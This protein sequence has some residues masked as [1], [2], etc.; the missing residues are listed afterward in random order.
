MVLTTE[1]TMKK[2]ILSSV[3][4]GLVLASGVEASTAAAPQKAP[5]GAFVINADFAAGY[6]ANLFHKTPDGLKG[7]SI[8][9]DDWMKRGLVA[10]SDSKMTFK[11]EGGCSAVAFGAV[12]KLNVNAA[13]KDFTGLLRDTYVFGRF[14]NMV[15]VRVG[16][17]RDAMCSMVDADSLMGGTYGYNGYYGNLL[18][19]T[20]SA[21][22]TR[23]DRFILDLGHKND[24]WYTNAIEVRTVRMA[25]VQAILNWKPSA[26]YNGRLGTYGDGTRIAGVANNI[27]SASVNYDNT[28]G[29]FRVRLSAG[30]VYELSDRTDDAGVKIVEQNANVTYRIGSAFS[31]K[32]FDFGL[33]WADDCSTGFGAGNNKDGNAGKKVHGVVGYQFDTMW[34]PRISVGALYGWKNGAKDAAI[35]DNDVTLAVSGAV[36]FNIRNG[37]RWFVEGTWAA[38]DY[39]NKTEA[40]DKGLSEPNLILGTGLAVSQ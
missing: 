8:D 37:L 26:A 1:K 30:S 23:K 14:G 18:K 24:S 10:L 40:S 20:M 25:G 33:G 34:K 32:S 4:A 15:E 11:T 35:K 36:D 6:W 38:L 2:L 27:L 29:D 9:P 7:D 19:S 31:W 16:S 39:S 13:A 21:N 12:V 17:Q 3:F 5:Y 22:Q 28:F